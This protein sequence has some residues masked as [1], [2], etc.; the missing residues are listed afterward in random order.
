MIRKN[1]QAYNI[2]VKE[3]FGDEIDFAMD[4]T[5]WTHNE[6]R[7]YNKNRTVSMGAKDFHRLIDLFSDDDKLEAFI[8]STNSGMKKAYR[9]YIAIQRHESMCVKL[10]NKQNITEKEVIKLYNDFGILMAQHSGYDPKAAMKILTQN[11]DKLSEHQIMEIMQ[12]MYGQFGHRNCTKQQ[13]IMGRKML[14]AAYGDDY[15]FG[16]IKPKY[17]YEVRPTFSGIISK[18][19]YMK[20]I[21]P[22]IGVG[23]S[24]LRKNSTDS[25]SPKLEIDILDFHKKDVKDLLLNMKELPF[26][27]PIFKNTN[28][29]N[30]DICEDMLFTLLEWGYKSRERSM[31]KKNMLGVVMSLFEHDNLKDTEYDPERLEA[32]MMDLYALGKRKQDLMPFINKVPALK[33]IKMFT[34]L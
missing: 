6:D 28:K 3:F 24:T 30:L 2:I 7:N 33:N 21:Y 11:V 10:S 13:S 27:E 5:M 34:K 25:Y 17:N 29:I 23:S 19:D 18:R 12:S 26:V 14:A 15:L 16:A 22:N 31:I 9:E 8:M 1:T 32:I 20:H 4:E